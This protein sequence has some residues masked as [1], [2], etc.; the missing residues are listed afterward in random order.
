MLAEQKHST[1]SIEII[2]LLRTGIEEMSQ[3]LVPALSGKPSSSEW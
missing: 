3:I 2:L 1:H